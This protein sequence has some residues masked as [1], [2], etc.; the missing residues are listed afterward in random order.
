MRELKQLD[1]GPGAFLTSRRLNPQAPPA[2]DQNN[3]AEAQLCLQC[4]AH[5]LTWAPLQTSTLSEKDSPTVL[6][7]LDAT[8]EGSVA[9]K[10]EVR[11]YATLKLFRKDKRV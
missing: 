6:G 9:E 8:E 2:L 3:Q 4:L 1:D 5:I 11:G 10:F 7:K